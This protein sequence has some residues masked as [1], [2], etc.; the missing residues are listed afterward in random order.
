[1][2]EFT[3]VNMCVHMCVNM[4]MCVYAFIGLCVHVCAL[5]ACMCVCVCMFMCAIVHMRD[6]GSVYIPPK[7]KHSLIYLTEESN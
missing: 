7:S 1:M 3:L 6:F 4:G 5:Q 2:C